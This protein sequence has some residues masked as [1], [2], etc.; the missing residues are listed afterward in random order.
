MKRLVMAICCFIFIFCCLAPDTFSK[1]STVTVYRDGFGVPH[2]F[3][4]DIEGLFYGFGHATAQDRLFQIDMLRRTYWGRVSE[5]HGAKFLELDKSMRRDNL[6]RTQVRD[7]IG[8]L[9]KEYQVVLRSFA[10]GIN[11]YI[12]EIQADPPQ[13]VP[14]EFNKFGVV[15]EQWEAED[16]AAVFNSVMGVFMDSQKEIEN[17]ALLD[18][19]IKKH[20]EKKGREIF[21]DCVWGNDP[22]GLT[23]IAPDAQTTSPAKNKVEYFRPDSTVLE[24]TKESE[25]MRRAYIPTGLLPSS[26][27][28]AASYAFV[29]SGK[30]SVTGNALLMGGP[31]FGFHL[32]S[33][34]YEA[35]LHG[36]G[37]SVVG[38]T[39]AG[40]PCL[41]FGHN[42]KSAFSS[43][44]GVDNITDLFE[45]KLN[46]KNPRQ[47]WFMGKWRT[48]DT[49]KEVF[50]VKNEEQKEFTFYSTVH[51]P[52]IRMDEGKGIAYSKQLSCKEDYLTGFVSFYELM[53]AQTPEDFKKAASFSSLSVNVYYADTSGNIGYFHQ[54]KYPKRNS[55]S[56]PLFP[57]P[58]TG[59]FEWQGFLPAETNPQIVNPT[60]GIIANWNNKPAKDWWNGDLGGIF[61]G[62]AGWGIDHRVFVLEESI[63]GKDRISADDLKKMIQNI[64]FTHL[65]AER[66]KPFLMEAGKKYKSSDSRMGKA[67]E[68][69]ASWDNKWSDQDND[70][71]YD[72]SG[73]TIFNSW[74]D[75]ALK[76]TFEDELGDYWASL[77]TSYGGPYNWERRK[78]YPG[79]PLFLRTLLGKNYSVYDYFNGK[80]DETLIKSLSEALD[81]AEK[82]FGSP[83]MTT[84]KTPVT[85][86]F[87]A[88]TTIH[89]VTSTAEKIKGTFFMERGT[90]NHIVELT[91]DGPKGVM[92][93]P[94]GTGG[95]VKINGEKSPNYEDQFEIFNKFE[96][97]PMLLKEEAVKTKAKSKQE[98]TYTHE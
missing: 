68:M 56:N 77:E 21:K 51:G 75:I 63:K 50:K 78:R 33:D 84:W 87:Y 55:G 28:L 40:Y 15:P 89:G 5:V 12:R 96:Y 59:E 26:D 10:A 13:R 58:G 73:L 70:G 43:T 45:E 48:M 92:V 24:L 34:L 94:P 11:A 83:D 93:V 6:S 76:N 97:K 49:R 14:A 80:R 95:F 91:K 85:P 35:G 22:D 38:S 88:P 2:I 17:R 44:A 69:L 67:L 32:P 74:W 41:M 53:K 31:Q 42:E 81:R 29:V 61:S 16:V 86:M 39:L 47:Y 3:S 7:Q 62:V 72:H 1:T 98:L 82:K 90:E 37:I 9:D 54:G 71:F 27:I 18:F 65:A 25:A 20:G 23:T 19:L 64:T 57:T 4:Q 66:F 30:R 60:T 46:P 79:N 36:P 8:A 52:V